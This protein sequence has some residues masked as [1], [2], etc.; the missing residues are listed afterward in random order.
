V[1]DINAALNLQLNGIERLTTFADYRV[2]Q[3]LRHWKILVYAPSLANKVDNYI[4]LQKSS[5]DEISIRSATVVAVEELV[6]LLNN[7]NNNNIINH[8]HRGLNEENGIESKMEYEGKK[9]NI[10][11]GKY[12]KYNDVTVDWYLW[13]VGERMHQNG[14]LKPF[15]RV[16]THFY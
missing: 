2:P 13:Q 7:N 4:E 6:K 10:G 11:N 16:R 9:G 14:I 8:H 1:G 12:C 15:H 3:V 5:Y